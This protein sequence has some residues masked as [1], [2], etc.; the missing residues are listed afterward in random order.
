MEEDDSGSTYLLKNL[1][2]DCFHYS[3]SKP[4]FANTIKGLF[5]V[6]TI[7]VFSDKVYR[8]SQKMYS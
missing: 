2:T 1:K 4:G 3:V 6:L 8:V 5:F 7:M